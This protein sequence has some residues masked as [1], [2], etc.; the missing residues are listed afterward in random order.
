ML[1]VHTLK[2]TAEL[3]QQ[4]NEIDPERA[5]KIHPNDRYRIERALALWQATGELPSSH[6]PVYD[7]I[8]KNYQ[9]FLL[10]RDR[11]EL[12]ERIDQRVI[13]MLPA[14]RE[15]VRG[16]KNTPWEDFLCRKKII[17]YCS[18]LEAQD[19]IETA[20]ATIQRDTRR[21]AKRQLTFFRSLLEQLP[22][23][24]CTTINMTHETIKD[25]AQD[26]LQRVHPMLYSREQK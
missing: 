22:A 26:I 23:D 8:E 13:E 4:L 15:E 2:S 6:A 18:L 25:V 12:Y 16:L 5:K 19:D 7:P 20:V 1:L 14:W 11:Q 21:Y 24:H 10:T 17:G 3:W 9:L